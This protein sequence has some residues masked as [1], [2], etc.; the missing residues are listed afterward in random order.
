MILKQFYLSC[1]AHASYIVIDEHT[2][3]AAVVDPQRD[4]E[5]YIEEAERHGATIGHVLLTHFHA[6]FI[7]G[8]LELRERLGA[9]I[10]LGV[11]AETEYD[12]TP[13]GDGDVLEFG[14]VRLKA[15]ETPGH[16]PEGVS[17]V[18]YD[19]AV[20][21]QAPHAV[22]TGDTLFVGDVGRPDLLA[23]IGATAEELGSMLYDSLR[24]K[25]MKLPAETIVYPAHGAGSMCG[26]NLGQETFTTIGEQLA[27][28]YALQP[29]TKESF[30]ALVTADQPQAPQYFPHD[31]VLNRKERSTLA[32]TLERGL[33][34]LSLDESL[35]QMNQGARALD[36]RSA[37]DFARSHLAGSV[38]IGLE[39]KFATWAGTALPPDTR[40][41]IVAAPGAEREAALRLGRIG[42]DNVVGYLDGGVKALDT[43]PDLARSTERITAEALAPMLEGDA[44]PLVVDV[45][46]EAEW[47]EAHVE[48]SMN[49]PLQHLE[50][51]RD[52]IP[53]GRDLVVMCRTGYRSSLAASLL[54]PHVGQD[55]RLSDLIGGIE[56]WRAGDLKTVVPASG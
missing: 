27:N 49:I 44:A 13:L 11:H 39:G 22:F 40:I 3:V 34:P 14:E 24:N 41:L 51:R 45:R 16:T 23:S 48:G 52:E 50:Q 55:R 2:K 15:L 56:A 18:V 20:N 1:L 6:D 5:Q 26:K 53:E 12:F 36:V 33:Q 43:R 21:D 46:T 10:Y 25:L 35:R 31:A 29:M 38:N 30:I 17:L 42:L 7:A 8:H 37:V 28:N 32:E 54:Q 47:D 4:I 9:R 19:L